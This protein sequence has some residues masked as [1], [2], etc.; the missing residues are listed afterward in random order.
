[1]VVF[2]AFHVYRYLGGSFGLNGELPGL[3]PDSVA[4]WQRTV[5]APGRHAVGGSASETAYST[6][7]RIDR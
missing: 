7:R 6:G 1:V 3:V 2:F 4:G 5:R